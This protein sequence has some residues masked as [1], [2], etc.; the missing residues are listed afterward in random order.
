MWRS[1]S[2]PPRPIANWPSSASAAARWRKARSITITRALIELIHG[3]EKIEIGCWRI[4]PFSDKH[5]RA[6]APVNC[7]EG[8][9]MIEAPRGVLIH[10]YKVDDKGPSCGPT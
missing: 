8:V 3:L 7:L 10:H 1:S 4:P 5:V 2:A 6:H 9:G